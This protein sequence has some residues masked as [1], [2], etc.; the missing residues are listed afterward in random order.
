MSRLS[1]NVVPNPLSMNFLN[2]SSEGRGVWLTATGWSCNATYASRGI[3]PP[4]YRTGP[5]SE[6]GIGFEYEIGYCG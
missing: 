1:W 6:E 5:S 2:L 3:F 4:G